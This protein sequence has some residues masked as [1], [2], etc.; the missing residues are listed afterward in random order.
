MYARGTA[1][2]PGGASVAVDEIQEGAAIEVSDGER[3]WAFVGHAMEFVGL[4]VPLANVFGPL[5]V[6]A[7]RGD[8]GQ[9]VDENGKQAID[10][11]ITRTVLLTVAALS[12]AVGL[13]LVTFP[14]VGIAWLDLTGIAVVRASNEEVYDYPLTVDVIS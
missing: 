4:V 1:T 8:E 10:F 9:F 13:G 6:C 5:L 7:I 12:I 2:E 14:I 3:T 11:Q